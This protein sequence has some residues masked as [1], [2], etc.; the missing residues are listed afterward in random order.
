MR[1]VRKRRG[2][3]P[4]RGKRRPQPQSA[5][6]FPPGQIVQFDPKQR[7]AWCLGAAA[8]RHAAGAVNTIVP[9]TRRIGERSFSRNMG[10]GV[11]SEKEQPQ[12]G[13]ARKHGGEAMRKIAG[14]RR[15]I[16]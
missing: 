3:K 16:S 11:G 9:N 12:A 15:G 8:Y 7:P 5:D 10:A 4:F 1:M 2:C 14:K 13:P 6:K